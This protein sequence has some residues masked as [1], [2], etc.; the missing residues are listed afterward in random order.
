MGNLKSQNSNGITS[1]Q[2]NHSTP[3][4]SCFG[5]ELGGST[6]ISEKRSLSAEIAVFLK[7][8]TF[9]FS[10]THKDRFERKLE[11]AMNKENANFIMKNSVAIFKFEA[12]L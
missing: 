1:L 5:F 9:I 12:L 7:I 10:L 2:S 11:N 8:F 3:K 4:S 6:V